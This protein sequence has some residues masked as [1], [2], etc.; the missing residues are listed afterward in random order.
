[1]FCHGTICCTPQGVLWERNLQETLILELSQ[2]LAQ[3]AATEAAWN[4]AEV[5]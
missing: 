4:S 2:A 3:N 1:M 5:P